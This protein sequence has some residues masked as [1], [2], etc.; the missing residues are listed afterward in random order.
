MLAGLLVVAAVAGWFLWPR[1]EPDLVIV[2]DSVTFLSIP[3]IEDAIGGHDLDIR[4]YPGQA[5]T[6][7][8]LVV[9]QELAE[10]DEV[11][12]DLDAIALLVGY[13][14][15]LRYRGQPDEVRELVDLASRARCTVVLTVPAPP[16]WS[17]Q[18]DLEA[19]RAAFATYNEQLRA[20]V[21]EHPDVHVVTRWQ[22]LVE[23][24][25]PGELVDTD[26]VHPVAAGQEALADVY[27]SAVE[28]SC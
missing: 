8:V 16:P 2:G 27:R 23:A 12:E 4:A 15:V 10:R 22:E 6:D 11:G 17:D 5:S 14:D 13:N 7:L 9:L 20:A 24:S 18:A 19:V 25:A 21:D 1:E 28:D 26:G 3:S